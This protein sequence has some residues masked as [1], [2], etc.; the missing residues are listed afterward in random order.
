MVVVVDE[1]LSA[2]WVKVVTVSVAPFSSIVEAI[3][4]GRVVDVAKCRG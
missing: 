1:V 4:S 3:S 2:V